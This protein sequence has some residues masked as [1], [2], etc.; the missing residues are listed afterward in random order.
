[1]KGM[2][3]PPAILAG[4]YVIA[5]AHVD[6]SIRFEQRYTLSAG[7]QWLGR[8]PCLAICEALTSGKFAIQHCAEDWEPLGYAG[9]YDSPREAMDRV[10]RSYHGIDSKWV[11][12]PTSRAEALAEYDDDVGK[13]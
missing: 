13:V 9:D 10:A 5:Y 4:L 8:V 11:A 1:M 3:A 7:G 6:D 2:E 12:N